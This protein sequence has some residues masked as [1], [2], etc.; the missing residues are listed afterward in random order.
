MKKVVKPL[1]TVYEQNDRVT[2]T[3]TNKPVYADEALL[4]YE[5]TI[6]VVV[7]GDYS[8][9]KLFEFADDDSIAD[10][11]GTIDAE[12]PQTDLGI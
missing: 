8:A 1:K 12:D 5:P 6:S 11:I 10:F 3:V 2:I 9:G 4:G 7:K